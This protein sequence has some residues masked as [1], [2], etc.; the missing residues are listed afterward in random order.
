M[1]FSVSV[2]FQKQFEMFLSVRSTLCS[3]FAVS[4]KSF[5]PSLFVGCT[6]TVP[7]FQLFHVVNLEWVCGSVAIRAMLSQHK[8]CYSAKPTELE[9]KETDPKQASKG[10]TRYNVSHG[11]MFHM[12]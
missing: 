8:Y 10:L 12:P 4:V 11:I 5:E 2:L 1:Q 7:V 6:A 9:Q 3:C